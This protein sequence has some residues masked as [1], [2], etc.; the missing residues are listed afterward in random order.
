MNS[1]KKEQN[2]IRAWFEISLRLRGEPVVIVRQEMILLCSVVVAART[3]WGC[4]DGRDHGL[5]ES[6]PQMDAGCQGRQG[7]H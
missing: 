4:Q 7:G 6:G 5:T 1:F 2:L 3:V